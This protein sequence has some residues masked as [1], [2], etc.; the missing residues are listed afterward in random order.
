VTSR[1]L[2]ALAGTLA[3]LAAAP[4]ARAVTVDPTLFFFPG[5][6][7]NPASARSAAL[8]IADRWLGDQ[9][10]D[11][12]AFAAGGEVE[13]SPLVEHPSRQDLSAANRNFDE[14]HAFVDA[15]GGWIAYGLRRVTLFAYGAQPVLRLEDNAFTRG[16]GSVDPLNPPA[17]ITSHTEARET[18]AGGGLSWGDSSFRLGVAAEW[19]R[20]NDEYDETERSGSPGAG[21]RATDFSGTGVGVQ[22]GARMARGA[23][24]AHPLILG[25]GAR[26]VPALTLSGQE[27]FTSSTPAPSTTTPIDGTRDAAFEGGLSA[28]LDAT[29]TLA[30]LAA[31]G[32]RT[33]Q[34]WSAL[35]TRAGAAWSGALGAE[36]HVPDEAWTA[37]AG[38]GLEREAEVPE[39]R[40]TRLAFG[41]AWQFEGMRL[42]FAAL[43]RAVA[44][45]G[46]PTA[47][48][49]RLVASVRVRY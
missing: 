30:L 13:L 6:P 23:G 9:P 12:P 39:A 42:D 24:G 14:T 3:V 20:R 36:L 45:D 15:A 10:F 18:R 19:T 33:A 17:A 26:F 1:S 46:A 48:D 7:A 31:V 16:T 29:P 34:D 27:V 47:Y 38:W 37:R 43:R 2:A 21:A 41:L 8:A 22:A 4:A 11:N 49:D 40:A 35:S 32:G 25:V 44:R 5:S 28:R